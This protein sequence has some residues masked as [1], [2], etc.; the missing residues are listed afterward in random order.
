MV[1]S[2]NYADI[3]TV[4]LQEVPREELCEHFSFENVPKSASEK[5]KVGNIIMPVGSIMISLSTFS[6]PEH[7]CLSVT[8][9]VTI[10]VMG[11]VLALS[12]DRCVSYPFFRFFAK[13]LC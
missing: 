9:V 13:N 10:G 2:D 4:I 6:K 11:V 5:K 12:E 8:S 1:S 3:A 7:P